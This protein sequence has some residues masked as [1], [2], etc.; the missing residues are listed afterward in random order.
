MIAD[1]R[2]EKKGNK[3]GLLTDHFLH[4]GKAIQDMLRQLCRRL[5]H[6]SADP[7][8]QHLP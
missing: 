3:L 1:T 5:F 8:G 2:S 6:A 4:L 7:K